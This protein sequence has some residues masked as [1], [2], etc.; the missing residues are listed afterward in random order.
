MAQMFTRER[1]RFFKMYRYMQD[2]VSNILLEGRD[3]LVQVVEAPIGRA[4]VIRL[5]V[6][7][8]MYLSRMACI[9]GDSPQE[10]IE[11]LRGHAD[12]MV[13]KKED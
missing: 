4:G 9:H 10:R 7:A 1:K 3:D 11:R 2:M 13:V 8:E 12:C 6:D 5:Y